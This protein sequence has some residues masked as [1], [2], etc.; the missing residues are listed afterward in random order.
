MGLSILAECFLLLREVF[1]FIC[2][3]GCLIL[4]LQ[5]LEFLISSLFYDTFYKLK[6]KAYQTAL[7]CGI[8][9]LTG[10]L[11][12]FKGEPKLEK[13][14]LCFR[15]RGEPDVLGERG[16][17]VPA[18]NMK[19]AE[20]LVAFGLEQFPGTFKGTPDFASLSNDVTC[21]IKKGD[22]KTISPTLQAIFCGMLNG[23]TVSGNPKTKYKRYS[24]FNQHFIHFSYTYL[25]ILFWSR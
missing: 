19:G 1:I 8:T 3:G 25:F 9:S 13:P 6:E 2:F 18:G 22:V 12:T 15:M 7:T 14:T 10:S 21:I 23:I 11:T 16:G 20:L 4:L 24:V 5:I 17:A